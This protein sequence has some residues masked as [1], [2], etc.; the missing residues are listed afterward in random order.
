MLKEDVLARYDYEDLTIFMMKRD[1][2]YYFYL[3]KD[4]EILD[5]VSRKDLKKT[6]ESLQYN[7]HE[8][9]ENRI[10]TKLKR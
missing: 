1:S 7:I 5:I 10:E 9:L 2:T 8:D 6:L 3:I 4:G